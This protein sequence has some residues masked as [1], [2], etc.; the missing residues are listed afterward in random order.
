M[1][2]EKGYISSE[3]CPDLEEPEERNKCTMSHIF[4]AQM[5]PQHKS[6]YL[7]SHRRSVCVRACVSGLSKLSGIEHRKES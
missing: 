5:L 4:M 6:E 1:T 2:G 7:L 3:L